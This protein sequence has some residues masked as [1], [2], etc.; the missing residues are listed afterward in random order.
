MNI[1][2]IG[3]GNMGEKHFQATHSLKKK[4]KLNIVGYFDPIKKNVKINN[5]NYVSEKKISK[6]FFCK[7]KISL[8]I[9]STPHFLTKKY[10]NL[11]Y[12]TKQNINIF[13]EKPLGLNFKE[14]KQI[15][16]KK[17]KK[18]KIF[19]GLN[20]RFFS[21]IKKLIFDLHNNKFGKL[22]SIELSMG[23]GHNSK[24]LNSWKL[25]KDKAG[26]GVIIDPGIHLINLIQ[27]I[28]KQEIKVK[29]C[30][31]VKNFFWKTGIE[32][33]T[34]IVLS[35]KKIPLILINLSIIKWRG[36]FII[37][38]NGDKGYGEVIGRGSHY[39]EQIYKT[40]AKW[41]WVKSKYKNQKNTE[42]I[43]SKSEEKKV[44]TI[45]MDS[46]LSEILKRKQPLKPSNHLD[47]LSSMRLIKEIYKCSK[48]RF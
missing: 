33:K 16:K 36:E 45:Q 10:V 13:L 19:V 6:E 9:I 20:Y 30:S 1:F 40:G 23:H 18:Q 5:I 46:V 15:C 32:E 25:N 38:V 2:F 24:M 8:C 42:I 35:S 3:M 31:I 21:G 39:G 26:G 34:L 37:Q 41:A 4:Y 22:S 27:L 12:S 14:A 28:F 48:K 43:R 11:I 17:R 7:K 29:H 47:A 44:F